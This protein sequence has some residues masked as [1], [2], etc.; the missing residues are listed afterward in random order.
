MES[1]DVYCPNAVIGAK[2]PRALIEQQKYIL[3]R[4]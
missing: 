3:S 1:G 4:P 2:Q